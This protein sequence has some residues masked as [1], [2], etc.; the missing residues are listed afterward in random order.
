[1]SDMKN[2]FENPEEDKKTLTEKH[3]AEQD[4]GVEAKPDNELNETTEAMSE[5]KVR[6]DTVK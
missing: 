2:I 3:A 4:T 5:A 6:H 1:M